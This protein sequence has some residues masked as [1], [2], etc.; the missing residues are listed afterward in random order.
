[1]SNRDFELPDLEALARDVPD[2]GPV[3]LLVHRPQAF[4][5]AARLGFPL[6]LA[7]H[8]HGGQLALPTPGGRYNL[9]RFM[10]EFDRGFFRVNGSLLFVNRGAG[11]GGPPLR[12]NCPREIT[13]LELH[14]PAS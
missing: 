7:G 12:M 6:V 10:T 2:A 3:V 5:Q 1:M 13:T 11:V 8:T 9:A 4:P 14:A